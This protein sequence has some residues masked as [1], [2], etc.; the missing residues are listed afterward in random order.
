MERKIKCW[1]RAIKQVISIAGTKYTWSAEVTSVFRMQNCISEKLQ[2][3]IIAND[4]KFVV[5][6]DESKAK[7]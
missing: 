5:Q 1:K 2:T 3:V 7:L 4:S 6:K